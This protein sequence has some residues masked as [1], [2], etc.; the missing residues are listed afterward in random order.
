MLGLLCAV[1]LFSSSSNGVTGKSTTGCAGGNCHAQN[2]LT[3][4]SLIGIPAT[5]YVNG[6]TYTMTLTVSNN[7]KQG[8][9]FDLT[10]NAGNITAGSGTQV[11]GTQELYHTSPLAM[12]AGNAV[13]TFTW[14]A[15]ATGSNPVV[16]FV[17]GNA[18]NLN[19]NAQN[20]A[21]NTDNFSFNAAQTAVLPT[22]TNLTATNITPTSATLNVNINAGNSPTNVIFNYGPT[23]QM[24]STIT[25]TPSVVTG[26][27]FTPV[28]ANLTGLLPN[29]TYYFNVSA[30]NSIGQLWTAKQNFNTSP[31]GVPQWN[32]VAGNA[33]PNPCTHQLI[34]EHPIQ[35]GFLQ[36]TV[37]NSLG[38]RIPVQHERL[39]TNHF[40][41]ETSDLHTGNYLLQWNNGLRSGFVSFTKQ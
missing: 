17:A 26:T 22:Y 16:F 35:Q 13:W 29:T 23:L 30:T 21:F 32:Q 4:I 41:F 36:F 12:N 33:Y 2:N 20:D 10:C 6:Q 24:G 14:T 38:Q 18:V 3:T 25:P 39:G 8:A 28:S 31:T 15:P 5:G 7:T 9:G 34:Y 11:S 1:L 40:V 27:T 19:N 37:Y